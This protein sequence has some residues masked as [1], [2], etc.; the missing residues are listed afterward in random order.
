MAIKTDDEL[1]IEKTLEGNPEGFVDLVLRRQVPIM[2][3]CHFVCGDLDTARNLVKRTFLAFANKMADYRTRGNMHT[4]LI[5]H[6]ATELSQWIRRGAQP[7]S[8]G[9]DYEG[10]LR[11]SFYFPA[12]ELARLESKS[13][14]E[15]RE[16]SVRVALVIRK[17]PPQL[18]LAA[19][20]K[21][22]ENL[23]YER[24]AVLLNTSVA[25]V[26]GSVSKFR[27]AV[28]GKD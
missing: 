14:D 24:I 28:L 5:E 13:L 4:L 25:E 27:F 20:L 26:R 21:I 3:L 19:G 2:R 10:K 8:N 15:I 7:V 9:D 11:D 16:Y 6:A 18:K 22:F 12:E 1:A 23:P 17:I